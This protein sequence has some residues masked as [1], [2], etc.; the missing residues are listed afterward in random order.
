M[1]CYKKIRGDFWVNVL[2]L[3][4]ALKKILASNLQNGKIHVETLISN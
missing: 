3:I 1:Q 4:S 2:R